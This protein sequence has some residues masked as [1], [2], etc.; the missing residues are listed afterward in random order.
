MAPWP[1]PV[2]E[3]PDDAPTFPEHC[4]CCPGTDREVTN[5]VTQRSMN[6]VPIRLHIRRKRMDLR[7]GTLQ[8]LTRRRGRE[9]LYLC[10]WSSRTSNQ[11]LQRITPQASAMAKAHGILGTLRERE[12]HL[13]QSSAAERNTQLGSSHL[14]RKI[15][16]SGGY[17]RMSGTLSCTMTMTKEV[18]PNTNTT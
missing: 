7:G 6:T 10:L 14:S 13:R 15:S 2:K 12:K 3:P 8:L 11:M 5:M 17:V 1:L 9:R 4:R 16:G 18:K